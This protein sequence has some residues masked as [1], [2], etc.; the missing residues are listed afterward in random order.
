MMY[1]TDA[2]REQKCSQCDIAYM[3]ETWIRR[4]HSMKKDGA[5]KMSVKVGVQSAM[6]LSGM[7]L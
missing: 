7:I 4:Y 1:A 3:D 2:V 5:P 6:S